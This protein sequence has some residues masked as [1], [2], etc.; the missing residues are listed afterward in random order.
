MFRWLAATLT[1]CIVAVVVGVLSAGLPVVDKVQ[2][3]ISPQKDFHGVKQQP[4]ELLGDQLVKADVPANDPADPA[5][6]LSMVARV[7]VP[8]CHVAAIDAQDVPAR[9][10]G[11]I[12][13]L[14]TELQP[15]EQAKV[16]KEDLIT[17]QIGFLA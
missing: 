16:A 10:D 3:R 13:F 5:L 15:G 7:V 8:D 11:E 1:L 4:R 2:E 14:G 9:V 6:P 12:V 17:E